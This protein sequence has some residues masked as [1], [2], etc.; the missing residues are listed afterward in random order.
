MITRYFVT[1]LTFRIDGKTAAVYLCENNITNEIMWRQD[2]EMNPNIW[3]EKSF[4]GVDDAL[5]F[6]RK[7]YQEND[8]QFF[9]N[10]D[11]DF[12]YGSTKQKNNYIYKTSMRILK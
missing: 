12:I 2:F 5:D 9:F 1:S 8:A 4:F 11:D 6:I 10:E 3:T 7:F